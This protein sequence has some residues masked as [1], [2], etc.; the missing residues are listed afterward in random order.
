MTVSEAL[1]DARRKLAGHAAGALEAD[2][3][4]AM[5][6][7]SIAPGSMPMETGNLMTVLNNTFVNLSHNAMKAS[8]SPISPA[9]GNSGHCRFK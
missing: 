5:L 2:L 7:V 6:S 8:P 4:C 1:A 3:C 9:Y